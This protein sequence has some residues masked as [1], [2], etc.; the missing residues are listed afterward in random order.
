MLVSSGSI[1]FDARLGHDDPNN[2]EAVVEGIYI[3]DGQIIVASTGTG[4]K[5]F[6]GEGTFV[7]WS[8]VEL[9]RDFGPGGRRALNNQLPVELFRH[10]P[11]LVTA[12]PT[13]FMRSRI[14]W[15]Q[16]NP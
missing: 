14:D 12:A 5:R 4:D 13:E 11:D 9:Q 3:A 8:G 2:L 6:I 1:T 15:Q 16:V 10:R 7:G